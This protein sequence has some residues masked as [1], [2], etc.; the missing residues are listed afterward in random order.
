MDQGNSD[1]YKNN[2]IIFKLGLFGDNVLHLISD[3]I[4]M[5]I[6]RGEQHECKFY[7]NR[8]PGW[9]DMINRIS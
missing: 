9:L 6:K 5:N 7:L 3:C 8:R 1:E 4:T 2:A